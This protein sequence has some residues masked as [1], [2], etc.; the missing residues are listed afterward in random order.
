M[1]KKMKG[2]VNNEKSVERNSEHVERKSETKTK[3][4]GFLAEFLLWFNVKRE[5]RI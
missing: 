2:K 5:R 4:E 1:N 3:N